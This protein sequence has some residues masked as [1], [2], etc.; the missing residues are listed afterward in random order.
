MASQSSRCPDC[1]KLPEQCWL[2]PGQCS[3]PDRPK[4]PPAQSGRCPDCGKLPEQCWLP[5]EQCQ[6]PHRPKPQPSQSSTVPTA[7]ANGAIQAARAE[8]ERLRAENVELQAK[9]A[10]MTSTHS[11]E[12]PEVVAARET[13]KRWQMRHGHNSYIECLDGGHKGYQARCWDCDWTGPEHL[14]GPEKIGTAESRAHKRHA[15]QDAWQHQTDTKPADWR[16]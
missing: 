5:P 12:P 2:P 4:P 15:R 11:V 6:H 1:S 8:A 9:L 16:L 3:H 10:A 13:I 7:L 14:R